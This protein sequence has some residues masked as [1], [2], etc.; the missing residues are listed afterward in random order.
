MFLFKGI[1]ISVY[2][3]LRVVA[4]LSMNHTKTTGGVNPDVLFQRKTACNRLKQRSRELP[5]AEI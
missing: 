2:Y 5:M 4:R 3:Y 1:N